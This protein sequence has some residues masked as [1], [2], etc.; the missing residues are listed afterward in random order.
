[1]LSCLGQVKHL[2]KVVNFSNFFRT[3]SNHSYEILTYC[4]NLSSWFV[5]AFLYQRKFYLL[6]VSNKLPITYKKLLQIVLI[7][8]IQTKVNHL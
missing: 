7:L 3:F 4:E 8:C 1:M 2:W 5:V 6:Q